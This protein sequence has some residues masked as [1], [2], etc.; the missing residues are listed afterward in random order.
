MA[1]KL[2]YSLVAR[3]TTV[4]AEQSFI[5]GNAPQIALRILEKLP[6]EDTRI[7]YAQDQHMYHVLVTEGVTFL[8]MAEEGLGRRLPFAFLED[9]AGRF[10]AAYGAACREAVAYEF[11]TEFSAVLAQRADFY[12]SDPAADTINRVRGEI[13]Q[14]KDVMIENIAKVLDR[15]EKL[16]L[17]VNKTELLQGEAF[18]FRRE[19]SRARRLMWWKNVKMWFVMAGCVAAVVLVLVMMMCGVTFKKCG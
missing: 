6:Q 8:T 2:L 1:H 4:L 10:M 3:G 15:G 9:V 13:S 7:S 14:V 5:T 17:L 18:A 12:S 16:D 11:N 19:A